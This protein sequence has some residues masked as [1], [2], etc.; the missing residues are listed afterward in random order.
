MDGA[1]YLP[2]PRVKKLVFLKCA[3]VGAPRFYYCR[4]ACAYV[5][6]TTN[7]QNYKKIFYHNKL[8]VT[9]YIL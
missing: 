1:T 8:L 6:P 9:K 7:R 3:Q 4:C 5:I 2:L